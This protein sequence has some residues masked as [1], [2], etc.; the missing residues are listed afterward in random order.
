M[1]ARR[2]DDR[3]V[4]VGRAIAQA[5]SN[6]KERKRSR[7]W[8][9]TLFWAL[10]PFRSYRL[11][12]AGSIRYVVPAVVA[13]EPTSPSAVTDTSAP[14]SSSITLNPPFHGLRSFQPGHRSTSGA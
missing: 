6:E 10:P 2:L 7:K 3:R 1:N 8:V 14:L 13:N 5:T 12:S 4:A 11:R 9:R